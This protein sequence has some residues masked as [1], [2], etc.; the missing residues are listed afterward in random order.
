MQPDEGRGHLTPPCVVY[1]DEE[2]L[3][4]VLRRESFGL[5]ERLQRLAGEAMGEGRN[6]HV[7]LRLAEEVDGLGQVACDRLA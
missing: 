2:Q 7:D 5:G 1:A 6:K 3:R 4:L